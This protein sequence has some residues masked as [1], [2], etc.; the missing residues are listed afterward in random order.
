MK[1]QNIIYDQINRE[2]ILCIDFH[3]NQSPLPWQ[4]EEKGIYYMFLS[5]YLKVKE[6]W[7]I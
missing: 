2:G 5:K 3:Y 1:G 4:A 6:P 7:E